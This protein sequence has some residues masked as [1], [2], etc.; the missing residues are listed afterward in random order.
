MLKCEENYSH[1][2]LNYT[3]NAVMICT[4]IPRGIEFQFI[5]YAI[6]F[7]VQ[8]LRAATELAENFVALDAVE[9]FCFNTTV[10]ELA[11][12]VLHTVFYLIFSF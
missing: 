8:P 12:D 3:T 4:Y 10:S 6:R 2:A 7:P 9:E 1:F 11:Q 5:I